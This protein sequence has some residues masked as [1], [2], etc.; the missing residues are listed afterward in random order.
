MGPMRGRAALRKKT[1]QMAQAGEVGFTPIKLYATLV[2]LS[3]WAS[4][5]VSGFASIAIA[6]HTTLDSAQL[7]C[8]TPTYTVYLSRPCCLH[9]ARAVG[10]STFVIRIIFLCLVVLHMYMQIVIKIRLYITCGVA[11]NRMYYHE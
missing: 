4:V 8:A 2:H 3:S 11:L 10:R 7:C 5:L 9:W 6:T 1:S